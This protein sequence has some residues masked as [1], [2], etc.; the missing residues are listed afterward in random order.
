MSNKREN[1]TEP[2]EMKWTR[3]WNVK[4]VKN[5]HVFQCRRRSQRQVDG[6]TKKHIERYVILLYF[7]SLPFRYGLQWLTDSL[8]RKRSEQYIK[9]CLNIQQFNS[10]IEKGM[11]KL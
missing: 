3:L 6:E 9:F 5:L 11:V 7:S 1:K 10:F 4:Y 8:T 2:R